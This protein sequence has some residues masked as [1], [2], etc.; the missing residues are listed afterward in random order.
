MLRPLDSTA[1]TDSQTRPTVRAIP[2]SAADRRGN[3]TDFGSTLGKAAV[4]ELSSGTRSATQLSQTYKR[5]ATPYPGLAIP[6]LSLY[7]ARTVGTDVAKTASSP[8]APDAVNAATPD[9]GSGDAA[10][11]DRLTVYAGPPKAAE[12]RDGSDGAAVAAASSVTTAQAAVVAS[13]VDAQASTAA[14]A[15]AGETPAA[16]QAPN[17]V[18]APVA[19]ETAGV[20]TQATT[21]TSDTT[22]AQAAT[23]A[24]AAA[25]ANASTSSDTTV[26]AEQNKVIRGAGGVEYARSG[27]MLVSPAAMR[28]D[29]AQAIRELDQIRQAALIP[30]TTPTDLQLAAQATIDVQRAQLELARLR[31]AHTAGA[32]TSH[33]TSKSTKSATDITA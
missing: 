18:Q 21:A 10:R 9:D 33:Q 6:D 28:Q 11:A 27:Q 24:N 2:L 25:T 20:A 26:A 15:I 31:Y 8:V 7:Q 4:L 32:D 19:T 29:P 3:D 22:T 1:F 23:T 14:Q 13:T 17:P 5:S 16:A 30:P 12:T